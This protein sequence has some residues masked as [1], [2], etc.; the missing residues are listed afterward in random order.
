MTLERRQSY[1]NTR[2]FGILKQP[3]KLYL[4]N[5]PLLLPKEIYLLI[6]MGHISN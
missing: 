6:Y 4:Q 1:S 3:G 2:G 5:L